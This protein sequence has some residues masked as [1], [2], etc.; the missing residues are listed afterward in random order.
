MTKAVVVAFHQYTPFGHEYYRPLLTFFVQQMKKFKNEY[1]KIYLIDSTWNIDPKDIEGL[2]AEIIKV[3]PNL[4][5]TEAYQHIL[6]DIKEDAILFVDNDMVVYREGIIAKTFKILSE[7]YMTNIPK[8]V[9]DVVSIYDDIGNYQTD[10]MNGKNKFCPYWFAAS[11]DTL[12][13][14]VDVY[15][16]SDMPEHETLGFLT[17][18]MLE[19]GLKSYEW[20]EDKNNCLF[21]GT[22]DGEKG[23]DL[24]YYHIRAGSTPAYLLATK[25][26]GE[27]LTYDD[28]LKNQPQN[29]YLR[30]CAF[31]DWMNSSVDK[32]AWIMSE[33]GLP[34]CELLDDVGGITPSGWQKYMKR[35]KEYHGLV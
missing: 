9:V 4:R 35:F 20:E 11:K 7:Q 6:P 30:Q 17:K 21:D 22:Q 5:Y 10:K 19:D 2:N 24:G 31:Y 26:Y 28:Y 23:K 29:E 3:D 32:G 15:W 33:Q 14:Y 16:G 34:F 13:K 1:D 18:R 8:P 25:K 27:R 12:M